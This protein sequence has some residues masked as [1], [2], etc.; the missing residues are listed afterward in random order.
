[1]KES[2][3]SPPPAA[4][5]HMTSTKTVV[6]SNIPD[7]KSRKG[8]SDHTPERIN[9]RNSGILTQ[10]VRFDL[11]SV[12]S[13]S[14]PASGSEES[15]GSTSDQES[16]GESAGEDDDEDY[17]PD[18]TRDGIFVPKDLDGDEQVE[19]IPETPQDGS[20]EEPQDDDG[21]GGPDP[22]RVDNDPTGPIPRLSPEIP[23]TILPR[24]MGA[25][26]G[27]R[28]RPLDL[29]ECY[30]ERLKSSYD[31]EESEVQRARTVGVETPQGKEA[32]QRAIWKRHETRDLRRELRFWVTPPPRLLDPNVAT[33]SKTLECLSITTRETF[34]RLLKE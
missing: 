26:L 3:G 21:F 7:R 8:S 24:L 2:L 11:K 29:A 20:G 23:P 19:V 6:G 17:D 32:L 34:S 4:R 5:R 25:V 30:H 33:V 28:E 9:D 22:V 15:V 16:E 18:T 27:K 31:D 1:M 12:H 13:N 14:T 10:S